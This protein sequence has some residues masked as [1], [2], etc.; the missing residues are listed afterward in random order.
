MLQNPTALSVHS[1]L[2]FRLP[3]VA[4]PFFSVKG[5]PLETRLRLPSFTMREGRVLC[6]KQSSLVSSDLK[7]HFWNSNFCNKVV[8]PVSWW[9]PLAHV[10]W[11]RSFLFN[12]DKHSYSFILFVV[13]LLVEGS[14]THT[15]SRLV[16]SKCPAE[17]VK[18]KLRTHLM[19]RRLALF[20]LVVN[21]CHGMLEIW[22]IAHSRTC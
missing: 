20:R 7:T 2:S 12:P 17:A 15:A 10:H 19:R 13:L 6:S 21:Y 16:E 18:T 1:R 22:R 9:H 4:E 8:S 3:H 11:R 14:S 5:L